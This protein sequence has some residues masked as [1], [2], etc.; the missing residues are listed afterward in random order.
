[1]TIFAQD[2]NGRTAFFARPGTTQSKAYTGTA[3]V[4][5]NAVGA[6]TRVVRVTT[7]TDA[8]I[9]FGTAPTATTAD[10]FIKANTPEFFRVVPGTDKIS[11]IQSSSGGTLYVTEMG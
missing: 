7:T 9:K 4:I 3:G 6:N 2:L 8:F 11:A 5:D 1:M 10:C